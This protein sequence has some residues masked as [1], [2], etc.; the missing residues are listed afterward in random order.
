MALSTGARIGPYTIGDEIGSGGMGEVYRA[1]D[2]NL[3]RDVALKTLPAGFASD[4]DRLAR[5]EREAKLLAALNHPNIAVIYGLEEQQ[6]TRCIAMELI[7]GE[8]LEARLRHGPLPVEEALSLALQIAE[9]LEA[10]HEKGVVHRDLKPANVMITRK[11]QV[12]VLD[13]GLGKVFSED[14]DQATLGQSPALSLA[15]TQQ[16]VVLGTAAYM[17]PEQASGQATDHRADVWAFGVV[18]FE[19][20]SGLPLFSGESVPHILADVLRTEPDWNRLPKNIDPR[21]KTL[22]DRCLRKKPRSRYQAIGDARVDIEEILSRPWSKADSDRPETKDARFLSRWIAIPVG[23]TSATAAML[24]WALWPTT[25][26]LPVNRFDFDLPD[27]QELREVNRTVI[28]I[29]PDGRQFVY[30]T[31]DGLFVRMMGELEPR[32][33]PGTESS[34][35]AAVFSPDGQSVAYVDWATRQLKR[36]AIGGGAPVVV[37]NLQ[38]NPNGLDWGGDDSIFFADYRQ[39]IFRV[40]ASGGTPE[41]VVEPLESETFYALQ[42]LP[43]GDSLLFT[44]GPAAAGIWN[45]ETSQFAVHSIPT[46]ERSVIA[47]GGSH[48]SYVSTGHILYAFGNDL[49]ALPFDIDTRL[50]TGGPVPILQGVMRS[51]GGSGNINSAANYSISDNGTLVYLTGSLLET[52]RELV[53]V[54]REGREQRIGAPLRT[55]TYPRI[56][57]DGTTVA[58]DVRDQ[59]LDIWTWNLSRETLTRLTFD[60]GEDEFPTWSPDSQRLAY[61][62]SSNLEGQQNMALYWRAADGTGVEELLADSEAQGS[63]QLYPASFLPDGTGVLIRSGANNADDIAV[64]QLR[65]ER[66][67][68]PI[69][70]SPFNEFNAEVSPDGRWLAYTSDESGDNEVYVR[71]YPDVDSGG[72]WQVS[73]GGGRQPLWARNGQELFYRNGD[74]VV[75]VAVETDPNFAVGNPVV[76]FEGPYFGAGGGRSY[77]VSPDGQQFLMIKP[78]QD[79]TTA[80]QIVIVENWFTELNRLAPTTK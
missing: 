54:D 67:L 55:Y 61:S 9:A 8:T 46:G 4:A 69:L 41:L 22:L 15:M 65:E 35:S 33:I 32:L 16:G 38:D 37:A 18:L 52:S 5:F 58:L 49:F 11:G 3:G 75:A 57:P 77:D 45:D 62:R 39:G 10:A 47:E 1:T 34:A 50:V 21:I 63:T 74:A 60:P 53:W 80:P 14:A 28:A 12:K 27:G 79:S 19:M 17:S 24:A 71:P 56:S 23:L 29:S 40:S 2:I 42:L 64:I 20:L 7:E 66:A 70:A 26:P 51:V 59:D 30:N 25:E 6:G 36:I 44:S 43:N 48:V 78:V 73:V 68:I 31:S 13:F 72:R 76:L